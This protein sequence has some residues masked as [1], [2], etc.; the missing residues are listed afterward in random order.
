M[1]RLAYSQEDRVGWSGEIGGPQRPGVGEVLRLGVDVRDAEQVAH[2]F[3]GCG[4]W[5]A[6]DGT[7][8]PI[9]HLL[10]QLY[11]SLRV[12]GYLG[13]VEEA[14]AH[15]GEVELTQKGNIGALGLPEAMYDG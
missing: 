10:H 3:G 9:L 4:M 12:P 7:Q 1:P 14:R 13:S 6:E 2:R 8:A 11:L 5:A 15:V